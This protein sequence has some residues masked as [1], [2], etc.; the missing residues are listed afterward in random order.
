M[1]GIAETLCI[2]VPVKSSG[3]VVSTRAAYADLY[4]A[5]VSL[6]PVCRLD[7][8]AAWARDR[9]ETASVT[10]QKF[11]GDDGKIEAQWLWSWRKADQ[12]P[13]CGTCRI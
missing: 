2:L 8:P 5:K 11:R 1:Y 6:A 10:A 12:D 13:E 3:R 4:F 7:G 9:K